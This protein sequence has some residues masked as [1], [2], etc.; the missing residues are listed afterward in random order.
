MCVLLIMFVPASM[1]WAFQHLMFTV[2]SVSMIQCS[3]DVDIM[4]WR[5]LLVFPTVVL[6]T[7]ELDVKLLQ[8]KFQGIWM[9]FEPQRFMCCHTNRC[10][11][12]VCTEL[13]VH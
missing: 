2:C 9:L 12:Y 11:W 6:Y 1:F 10:M 13:V 3:D 7:R 8:K 4:Q 5:R